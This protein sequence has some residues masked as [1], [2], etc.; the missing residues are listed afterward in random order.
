M[1]KAAL[2]LAAVALIAGCQKPPEASSPDTS[3]PSAPKTGQ[4]LKIA[5][6]PKNTGNPY[7]TDVIHGFQDAAK[8]SGD[9]FATNAPASA[10]EPQVPII[11]EQVQQKV[12]V[13]VV[14]ASSPDALN[15]ALDDAKS[16]GILVLTVDA[17]LTGNEQHRDAA[18]LQAAPE[19]V[20]ESQI[21]LLGKQ[22]NYEGDFAVLS[23]T[24]DAPNQNAWIAAMQETL[25]QPKYA[26]MK[27][28]EI[29]YGDDD[30]QKSTTE[31][32]ALL[33]KHPGLRGVISPTSVGLAAAARS[34]QISGVFPGG[35]NAK[36][37]GLVLTGLSTPNQMKGFVKAGVVQEF[38]L[39]SPHDMGYAAASLADQVK[40]GKVK[41]A[42]GTKFTAGKLGE[43]TIGKNN[44]IFACPLITFDKNNIDQY[45][46]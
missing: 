44:V 14:S 39:W 25:K 4:K 29:A 9:D 28:I 19:A 1:W 31:F 34:L 26:K 36:G 42:E 20:G 38:Q 17:D 40:A 32:E 21:E 18:I 27:L 16:K 45:D 5:Y 22:I 41:I 7:F 6:I 46:F 8:E 33:T 37:P 11:Q 24:K 12:D 43:L 30:P 2:A 35:P 3:T 15:T 13:I 23:A 10:Q